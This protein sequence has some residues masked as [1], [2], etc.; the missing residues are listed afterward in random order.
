[1]KKFV[2]PLV[3]TVIVA[4]IALAA[5]FRSDLLFKLHAMRFARV[6]NR[7]VGLINAGD[8]SGVEGLFNSEMSQA[9][10][11]ERA[12]DFFKAIGT[13]FGKIIKLDEPEPDSGGMIFP[14]H[15]ERGVFDLSL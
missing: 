4:L 15:C 11:P 12:P 5:Y 9:L 6:A 7:V 14:A 2:L 13:Q 10:P 1:M 3:F 8:Y